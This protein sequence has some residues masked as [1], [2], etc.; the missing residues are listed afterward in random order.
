MA[1][2]F[3][4][5]LPFLTKPRKIH[6]DILPLTEKSLKTFTK[7]AAPH[8]I[9]QI[10]NAGFTAKAQSTLTLLNAQ[11]DVSAILMGLSTPI[12]H[13]DS[14][15]AYNTAKACLS[16]E[17]LKS[18]SFAFNG[19]FD[20]KCLNKLHIG[21][22]LASYKFDAYIEKPSGER[23][24]LVHDKKA[25]KALVETTLN[26]IFTLKNLINTPANDCGPEDLERYI[27]TLAK[28]R[29]AVVSVVK[30]DK[31]TEKNFPLIYTVGKASPRR[32][33][34]IELNW[35]RESAPK[36]TLVGKGVAFDTGGLDIKPSQFMRHMKKDMGGA[37]HAINLA[38]MIMALNLPVRL[39][40]LVAAVENAIDGNAFRPGDIIKS[41]KGVFVEN[42]NTDAEGRLILAD[43]L[44][45]AAEGEPDLIID[46]ATLTGS[47]RAALGPDIPGMFSNNESIARDLQRISFDCE[48]PVWNMPLYHDYKKH[49]NSSAADIVNSA[50]LPGDLI[51]SALFLESFLVEGK[52]S[53]K[54]P[55]WIHLDCY[56]WEQT[57]RP[58][59]PAGAADT[60]LRAVYAFL[61]NKYGTKPHKKTKKV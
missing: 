12:S 11:G 28:A 21:W 2:S 6:I 10:N 46:Y 42:T 41:R 60:G 33:R 32:P 19:T 59:R 48:D 31:L 40:L 27:K 15:Y 3:Q 16:S 44:T 20:Q 61:N 26:A 1:N 58:G 18:A 36:I 57:G 39:K 14:A 24:A 53:G 50:G 47:A 34:L 25:D 13:Y 45:Y 29:D 49:L 5:P 30:D 4:S 54:V 17:A 37:A 51:Y 52:K 9:K 56:A 7:D 23:P 55:D 22:G 8:V 35:G 38:H 43:T